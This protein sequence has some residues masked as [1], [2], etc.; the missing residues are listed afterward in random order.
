VNTRARSIKSRPSIAEQRTKTGRPLKNI[1]PRQVEQLAAIQCSYAEM[2]AVLGC[3]PSTLTKRFSQAI[4]KG[5]ESGKSSLKR[6]QFKAALGGNATML[7]WLGK[8]YLEQRDYQQLRIGNPDDMALDNAP[9]IVI[10]RLI[11]PDNNRPVAPPRK[12]AL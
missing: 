9:K 11:L 1:D 12:A 7:I 2:A 10:G 6:A 4:K 8:Q 3:D 5:R